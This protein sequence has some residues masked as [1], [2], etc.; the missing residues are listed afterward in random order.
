M[1]WSIIDFGKYEKANITLPQLIF[2]DL[3]YFFWGIEK[4]AF[5]NSLKKEAKY[6]FHHCSTSNITC[7]SIFQI[8]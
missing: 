4:G 5:K 3:D 7:Y 1:N 8:Q 2:R 6:I